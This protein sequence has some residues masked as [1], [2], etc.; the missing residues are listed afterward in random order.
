MRKAE[1]IT[2]LH[3]LIDSGHVPE[4]IGWVHDATMP[5]WDDLQGRLPILPR[6]ARLFRV[7]KLPAKPSNVSEVGAPPP[8]VCSIQRLND[9]GQSV[10]YLSESPTTAIAECRGGPGYYCL[11]EWR[12]SSPNLYLTN[13]GMERD[14]MFSKFPKAPVDYSERELDLEVFR[15]LRRIFTLNADENPLLY[16]WSIGCA[17]TLKFSHR[18]EIESI[19]SLAAGVIHL[20]GRSVFPGIAYASIRAA[21]RAVNVALNDAGQ[22]VVPLHHVQWIEV[23]NSK[24]IRNIDYCATWDSA[25]VLNW[26][27]S[28][29]KLRLA[30]QDF[31]RHEDGSLY[32]DAGAVPEYF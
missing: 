18:C 23:I 22:R 31:V 30:A 21:A 32:H 10:L 4:S 7:R 12:V 20:A 27:G 6:G 25:G 9:V 26:R 14:F 19:E 29:A 8:A 16:R 17:M 5:L 2:W 24:H 28:P 1:T 13:G 15:L 11:T 3:S